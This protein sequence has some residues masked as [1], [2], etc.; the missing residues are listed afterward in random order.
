MIGSKESR[1]LDTVMKYLYHKSKRDYLGGERGNQQEE[2]R[3]YGRRWEGG[4]MKTKYSAWVCVP[5]GMVLLSIIMRN[6][7]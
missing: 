3:S 2:E 6:L 4:K 5:H 1:K 7:I